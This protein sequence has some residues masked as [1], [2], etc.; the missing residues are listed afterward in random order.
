[1]NSG[2]GRV[3][4]LI[5]NLVPAT[6]FA[7]RD[8]APVSVENSDH[9]GHRIGKIAVWTGGAIP[10]QPV[11]HVG[12]AFF[13]E[14]VVGAG[15]GTLAVGTLLIPLFGIQAAIIALILIKAASTMAI[16]KG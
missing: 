4:G 15:A 5:D 6:L 12:H 8:V 10:L 2:C 14:N 9:V 11:E 3:R 1:M 16:L 7:G 13:A